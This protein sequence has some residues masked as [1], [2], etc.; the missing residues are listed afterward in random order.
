ML[1][2]YMF[3]MINMIVYYVY[4]Y[5]YI[6]KSVSIFKNSVIFFMKRMRQT[7]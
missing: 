2:V 4:I 7:T 6:L 1:D 3:N 5:I